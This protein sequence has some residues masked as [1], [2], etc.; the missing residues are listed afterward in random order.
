MLGNFTA[1]ASP[2]LGDFMFLLYIHSRLGEMGDGIIYI[3]SRYIS[4]GNHHLEAGIL[5]VLRQY[6]W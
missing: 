5:E 3:T 4:S 6:Q 1:T 2:R